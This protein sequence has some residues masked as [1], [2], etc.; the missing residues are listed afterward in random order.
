[1]KCKPWFCL[2]CCN[3]KLTEMFIKIENKMRGSEEMSQ[4]SLA[5]QPCGKLLCS[6]TPSFTAKCSAGSRP[7][8]CPD[9]QGFF[10]HLLLLLVPICFSH[11]RSGLSLSKSW[12]WACFIY[13]LWDYEKAGYKKPKDGNKN[14]KLSI[15]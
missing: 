2:S 15:S 11:T 14:N 1:M 3:V 5:P 9:I 10:P 4:S 7:A 12:R 13:S 6:S 8:L